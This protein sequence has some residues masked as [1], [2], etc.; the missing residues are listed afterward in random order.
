MKGEYFG[1]VR[2]VRCLRGW[3]R[4]DRQS[5]RQRTEGLSFILDAGV[6]FFNIANIL[7]TV[8]IKM[9]SGAQAIRRRMIIMDYNVHEWKCPRPD[10]K[11]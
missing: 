3:M 1:S 11:N 8:H 9:P 7:F 2:K 6:K 10:L 4:H 5:G